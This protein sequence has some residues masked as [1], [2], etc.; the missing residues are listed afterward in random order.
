M[1]VAPRVKQNATHF[2]RSLRLVSGYDRHARHAID[3]Y[4]SLALGVLCA[5]ISHRRAAIDFLPRTRRCRHWEHR[6]LSDHMGACLHAPG[7]LSR[8]EALPV[9][10]HRRFDTVL[11]TRLAVSGGSF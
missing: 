7:I 6:A 3:N 5:P 2:K 8:R 10:L 1:Y 9:G 4:L 11:N